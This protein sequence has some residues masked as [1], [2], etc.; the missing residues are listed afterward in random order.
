MFPWHC[1]SLYALSVPLALL[2]FCSQRSPGIVLLLFAMLPGIA[3]FYVLT[4][5]LALLP[6]VRNAPLALLP[7]CMQPTLA[8][9]PLWQR[10]LALL[11]FC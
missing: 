7:F 11:P 10:T 2:P 1:P 6:F 3:S 5:P 8:L 4:A 9:L